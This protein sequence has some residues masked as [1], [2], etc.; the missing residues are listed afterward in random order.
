MRIAFASCMSQSVF[1]DQPVW[2]WIAATQPDHLLLLGDS[3][4]LDID[5][6]KRPALMSDDEFAQL[7]HLRWRAQLAQPQFR[8]LLAQLGRSHASA[9]WDDHDFLWDGAAGGAIRR[10]PTQ[11]GKISLSNAFFTAFRAALDAP[12]SF[13]ASYNDARFWRADE[14]AP[15]CPSL[16]LQPGLWLHL[17][18]GR[19][20]R[21]ETRFVAQ[22][23]RELLGAA[24]RERFGRAMSDAPQALHL[25]ASGSTSKD[26]KSFPNDWDWLRAQAS[27]QRILLLSG[28]VH[29]NDVDAFYTGGLPLH[30]A[31]SSGAAVRDAVVVGSKQ[32]NYGL[33][34][35]AADTVEIRLFKANQPEPLLH[36]KLS[37]L[38]WLPI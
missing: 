16:E 32:Q 12:D 37:R 33:L 29:H 23:Q 18:D 15:A 24:Q 20:W 35:I 26:W 28:D 9:I 17:S 34:D 38:S 21:T 31:T 36:R 4:Y 6:P 11:N 27:Q 19:S 8:A 25:F 30:E 2:S 10:Q 13:P 1:P 5:A 7:L 14:P 3:I 22:A